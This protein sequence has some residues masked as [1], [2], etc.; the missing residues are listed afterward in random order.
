MLRA[1][2]RMVRRSRK[3]RHSGETGQLRNLS[4]FKKK[5][6]STC[7]SADTPLYESPVA[8]V[9]KRWL[10]AIG[11]GTTDDFA[12][13]RKSAVPESW[14]ICH[15]C[16]VLP[17]SAIQF[18]NDDESRVQGGERPWSAQVIPMLPRASR[19]LQ[20]VHGPMTTL[21]AVASKGPRS[22]NRGYGS[23]RRKRGIRATSFNGSTV[24]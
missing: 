14:E 16:L 13:H 12:K 18:E 20:W 21:L 2:T 6:Q 19:R 7:H 11:S 10:T 17:T 15:K 9:L 3:N 23:T 8:G 24:R 22:N 4:R 5:G 1:D